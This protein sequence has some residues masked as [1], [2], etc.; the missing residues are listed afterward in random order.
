[1]TTMTKASDGLGEGWVP[2][3]PKNL[4][5]Q[6]MLEIRNTRSIFEQCNRKLHCHCG[7][8]M[9]S[10]LPGEEVPQFHSQITREEG[11]T[12]VCWEGLKSE[13]AKRSQLQSDREAAGGAGSDGG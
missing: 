3:P 11:V 9:V 2:A 12:G 6:E 8:L 10:L 1:M 4:N 13:A 7:G 5:N